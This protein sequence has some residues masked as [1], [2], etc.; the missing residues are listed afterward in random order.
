MHIM[1]LWF[2]LLPCPDGTVD[3]DWFGEFIVM[4][5][6]VAVVECCLVLNTLIFG[7]AAWFVSKTMDKK[8][9]DEL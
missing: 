2:S 8:K 4:L 7:I 6:F 3:A 5:A 9:I 1:A